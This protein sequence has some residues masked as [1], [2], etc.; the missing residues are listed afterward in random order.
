M[1]KAYLSISYQ[2]RKNLGAEIEAMRAV[3]VTN[4]MELFVFVDN[5]H[6]APTKEKQM[7]H[8]AFTD[9]ASAD[10]LIAEVSEKAIGVGIEIG[11]AAALRK[12]IIYLRNNQSEHSTTASGSAGYSIIYQNAEDLAQKMKEIVTTLQ[13]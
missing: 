2:N 3:L 12:P 1:K 6:F 13:F 9:I 4:Q 8:Q 11:Y 10:L 5:Y 7:M